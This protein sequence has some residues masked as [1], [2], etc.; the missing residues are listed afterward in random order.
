[1]PLLKEA[2]RLTVDL[3]RL[4]ADQ[5]RALRRNRSGEARRIDRRLLPMRTQLL[6]LEARLEELAA[7]HRPEATVDDI[8]RQMVADTRRERAGDG[9]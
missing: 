9:D 1:M 2:G 8:L 5:E 3:D 6:T 7:R 4:R